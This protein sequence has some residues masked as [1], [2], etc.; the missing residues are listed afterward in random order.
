MR[1][2]SL[3]V[4][5]ITLA[6]A[7]ALLLP[8]AGGTGD[9]LAAEFRSGSS[10]SIGSEERIDDDLYIS[11]GM[12]RIDGQVTGDLV[13]TG[14]TVTA[15]G[16]VDGNVNIASG[17]VTVSG[18]V[19]GTV[20]VAAGTITI[21]GE[22]ARDVVVAGGTVRITSNARVGQDLVVAGGTVTVDGPVGRDVRGGGGDFRL[23]STVGGDVRLDLDGR[24][25]LA[26]NASIEGDL[27]YEA[28]G[29]ANIA[30]GATVAGTTTR[31]QPA[32]QSTGARVAS[33]IIST[34]LRLAWA[35]LV[36]TA[37][38]LLIPRTTRIVTDTLRERPVVSLGWGVALLIAV[39]LLAVVLA[40]TIV[41]VP[42]AL[43]ALGLLLLAAY[44]SQIVVGIT[45][46]RLLLRR[47]TTR[48]GLWAAML[49]GVTIVV[50]IRLL[51]IPYGWTTWVSLLIAVLAI[52]A[53]WTE[54][55]GWGRY[56]R[57]PER[58]ATAPPPPA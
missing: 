58:A 38:V 1:I 2:R 15:A 33:W 35:L 18:P 8:V 19:G 29:A 45:I 37:I 57:V 3:Q 44:L 11:G 36:G 39:P 5:V 42:L 53:I 54:L 48:T 16:P 40:V 9:A 26:E 25:T 41:G 7:A 10:P 32:G 55:T 43:I 13:A 47:P 20:R 46:G 4:F 17:N 23:N 24:L 31:E 56:A 30:E 12:I 52:G 34:L 51:P 21:D 22:V 14:G 28:P 50:L 49:V 6:V 27:I